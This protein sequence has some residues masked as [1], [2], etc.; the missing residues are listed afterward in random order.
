MTKSTTIIGFLLSFAAGMLLMWGLDSMAASGGH[1]TTASPDAVGAGAHGEK[2]VNPGAVSVALHV[3]SQCPYGVQAENGFKD[4]VEKLGGDLDLKLEFIGDNKGGQLT[5]MHGDKEVKGNLAQICAMKHSPKWFDMVMCQNKNMREVD[6]NWEACAKEVG[7][8]SDKIK[9]CMEGPEGQQLLAESFER[10]KKLGAR[11]SPTIFIGGQKYEGGRRPNDFLKAVCNAYSGNK[12]AAC[13]SIPESPKVNITML[14]DKRCP[15]CNTKQLEGQLRSKVANPVV[16]TLDYTDA[17]G[18]KLYDEI[19]PAM[20]P[21]A[22]FDATIDADK[23]ASA[24]LGRFIKPAGKHKIISLGGSWNPACA[25]DGGCELEE[26]AKTLQCRKEEPNSLEVFVM[27]Q[28]PF[29][30]KGLDA[31]QEVLKNFKDAGS[32][33]NFKINFIGDGDASSLKSM[34]GQPE[35]DEDIRE[36]CAIH[37]YA[38]DRKYMDYIW[39][40][41]KNIKSADWQSCTGGDTGIDTE[42]IKTCFEGEEGKKLLAES[43]AYSKSLGFGASP[44]W[45]ANGRYK[46]SGVDPETIKKNICEHNKLAGCEKTLSGPSARAAAGAAQP[47]C[48]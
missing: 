11:G 43:F 27:S 6:T 33:I 13:A 36:V 41:D 21:L 25:D 34:H 15:E 30:V 45:L 14:G 47:G 42:V 26:C 35:V 3:M 46:F 40:R 32:D 22:V 23:E 5:S 9:A 37:H 44:T 17:A 8:P 20:L 19:K 10:S 28:C 2:V 16:T 39:C 31:M 38:K 48:E 12:P 1:G 29:G 24:A 4:A 7:A 18:K